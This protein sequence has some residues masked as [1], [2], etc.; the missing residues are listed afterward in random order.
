VEWHEAGNG[1]TMIIQGK[2]LILKEE[3]GDRTERRGTQVKGQ[4][5]LCVK[6][7]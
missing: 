1:R 4:K 6:T 7:L 2:S 5:Y 3:T